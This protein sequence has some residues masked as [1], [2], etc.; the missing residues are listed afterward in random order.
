M[1]RQLL[2]RIARDSYTGDDFREFWTETNR[3]FPHLVPEGYLLAFQHSFLDPPYGI[4]SSFSES[5]G[6]MIQR[7]MDSTL[8]QPSVRD[9]PQRPRDHHV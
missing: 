8:R 5:L 6:P 4:R 2:N 3:V 7:I 1:D 9:V